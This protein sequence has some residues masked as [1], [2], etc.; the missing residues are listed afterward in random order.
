LP[1]LLALAPGALVGVPLDVLRTNP[2]GESDLLAFGPRIGT[3]GQLRHASSRVPPRLVLELAGLPAP[4]VEAA[5]PVLRHAGAVIVLRSADRGL[6]ARWADRLLLPGGP[7]VGWVSAGAVRA[8][9]VLEIRIG[10]RNGGEG[11]WVRVPLGGMR[12]AEAVLA[13]VR[14]KGMRVCE[15]RIA[16]RPAATR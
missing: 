1:C 2:S 4:L 5:L 6:L 13:A 12:E 7:G 15:S 11:Q 16:Y 14:A 3:G 8:S 10:R 9:R